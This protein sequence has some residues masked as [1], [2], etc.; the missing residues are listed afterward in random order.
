SGSIDGEGGTGGS[1]RAWAGDSASGSEAWEHFTGWTRRTA[2]ERFRSCQVAGHQQSPDSHTD[3]FWHARLYR[4]RAGERISRQT[5]APVG[6]IQFG[7]YFVRFA[8]GSS[9]IYG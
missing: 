4:T 3:Y 5:W 8:G 2:G 9:A 7:C 6:R 1:V